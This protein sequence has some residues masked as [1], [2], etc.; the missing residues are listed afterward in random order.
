[1]TT[2]MI[3]GFT[4]AELAEWA[5]QR[6]SSHCKDN[7]GRVDPEQ[8]TRTADKCGG[9]SCLKAQAAADHFQTLT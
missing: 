9:Q 2:E 1:M 6:L 4:P 3:G 7:Q 8:C 5:T